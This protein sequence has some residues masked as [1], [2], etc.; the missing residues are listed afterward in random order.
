MGVR[1]R[2]LGGA[3]RRR[4]A[5]NDP[6]AAWIFKID[7]TLTTASNSAV[8][9][10]NGASPCSNDNITWQVGSSATLGSA[11]SFVGNILASASVTLNTGATSTGGLYGHTGAVTRDSDRV[12]T[13]TDSGGLAGPADHDP[14]GLRAG[15]RQ[16]L[17]LRDRH[18]RRG[19]HGHRRVQA[20][21]P[22]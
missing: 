16:H 21:R 9:L 10:V 19:P 3:L 22:R 5:G 20:L 11:T 12:S 15:R 2:R 18:R 6:T 17:R 13:C 14:V 7:S 4:R 1:R 8:V